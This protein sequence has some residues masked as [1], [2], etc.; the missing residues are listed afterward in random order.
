MF[1]INISAE[2][3][4]SI[5]GQIIPH[6]IAMAT[7]S[8]SVGFLRGPVSSYI[9]YESSN[10]VHRAHNVLVVAQL[11]IQYLNVWPWEFIPHIEVGLSQDAGLIQ[12]IRLA[13]FPQIVGEQNPQ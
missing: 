10:I 11:S 7:V 1:E 13:T 3:V 8:D 2:V 12:G 9:R 6:V 5:P 4:G